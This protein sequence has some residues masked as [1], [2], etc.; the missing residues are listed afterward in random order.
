MRQ[1]E[2]H[3][4]SSFRSTS[5]R[6]SGS[7]YSRILIAWVRDYIEKETGVLDVSLDE[8]AGFIGVSR[9]MISQVKQSRKT[10]GNQ[11]FRRVADK[12]GLSLV[13]FIARLAKWERTAK[14]TRAEPQ[15]YFD[16]HT[17]SLPD[18]RQWVSDNLAKCRQIL[19][20]PRFTCEEP[21]GGRKTASEKAMEHLLQSLCDAALPASDSRCVVAS[22]LFL[23]TS[24]KQAK[25]SSSLTLVRGE[26]PGRLQ[27][28]SRHSID[29]SLAKYVDNAWNLESTDQIGSKLLTTCG[30]TSFCINAARAKF[31]AALGARKSDNL[32]EDVILSPVSYRTFLR[33]E[34]VKAN[35]IAT[36]ILGVDLGSVTAA[37]SDSHNDDKRRHSH[38]L[39]FRRSFL[40]QLM[41][42][43]TLVADYVCT[44]VLS[45]MAGR[46]GNTP[47]DFNHSFNSV[48]SARP[49]LNA[50][51][52]ELKIKQ[53]L[54]L[55]KSYIDRTKSLCNLLAVD[56][57]F[58]EGGEAAF[59]NPG[60][61]DQMTFVT[62]LGRN[63][64]VKD[65]ELGH[66]C[67]FASYYQTNLEALCPRLPHGKSFGA[68]E[69]WQPI[70]IKA[71]SIRPLTAPALALNLGDAVGVPFRFEKSGFQ[72]LGIL[73]F[74]FKGPVQ[75][76]RR[77]EVY[78]QLHEAF[79]EEQAR[80]NVRLQTH[81]KICL[82]SED[83][84]AS[85]N[86]A[87]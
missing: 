19:S 53:L 6:L 85:K 46:S 60:G 71:T 17:R 31:W 59:H 54:D 65:P 18:V 57:W 23:G 25:Q 7:R 33:S 66:K 24:G 56:A 55:L 83:S 16:W 79:S 45:A 40:S 20:G 75:T 51:V 49:S 43:A 80:S 69:E 78:K 86:N 30:S 87:V 84:G 81:F 14:N 72:Q 48:L 26:E 63:T 21:N 37:K 10:F 74:R 12:L 36:L 38:D 3:S 34:A 9:P 41:A 4:G 82:P 35:V 77:D 15:S 52:F 32:P 76:R 39:D 22:L 13:S 1:F 61:F 47:F 73:W 70:W 42:Q 29:K 27:I 44:G 67:S 28:E 8:I 64:T 62:D 58:I 5:D 68:I 50:E 11:T 2:D